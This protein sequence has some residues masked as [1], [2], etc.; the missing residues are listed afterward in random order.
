MSTQTIS[1]PSISHRGRRRLVSAALASVVAVGVTVAVVAVTSGRTSGGHPIAAQSVS[2]VAQPSPA[3]GADLMYLAAEI[4][5]MSE[6]VQVG[7]MDGLSP[8]M[9]QFVDT[10]MANQS[11]EGL[12]SLRY[13]FRYT[14]PVPDE[15][16][17]ACRTG[18]TGSCLST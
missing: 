1:G 15:P 7:V 14:P 9:R 6:Q 4:G 5:T 12:G 13:G 16:R 11:R 3:C 17:A 8:Q 10:A 2:V 18:R